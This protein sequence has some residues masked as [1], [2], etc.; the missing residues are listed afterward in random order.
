MPTY[1]HVVSFLNRPIFK[2]KRNIDSC[3]GLEPLKGGSGFDVGKIS[4]DVFVF[5]VG[6]VDLNV[7]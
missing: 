1:R 4:H 7:F 2:H 6:I 5:E 3:H